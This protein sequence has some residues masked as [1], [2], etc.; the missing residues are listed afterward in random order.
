V[1]SSADGDGDDD[2]CE[3][4]RFLYLLRNAI[5]NLYI[6]WDN[7]VLARSDYSRGSSLRVNRAGWNFNSSVRNVR[8]EYRRIYELN[9]G[10]CF[11]A[12][13]APQ[14]EAI[15]VLWTDL[16]PR[17]EEVRRS[18]GSLFLPLIVVSSPQRLT[19]RTWLLVFLGLHI[20][21]PRDRISEERLRLSRK[22]ALQA[23][24]AVSQEAR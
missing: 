18:L 6:G 5:T 4:L 22:T 9:S 20:E 13:R 10:A 14:R 11:K 1:L 19:S 24:S 7:I 3:C 2:W 15:S 21:I 17:S 16:C 23:S 8:R 12:G